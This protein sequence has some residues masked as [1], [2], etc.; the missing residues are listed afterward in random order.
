MYNRIHSFKNN[1]ILIPNLKLTQEMLKSTPKFVSLDI[2]HKQMQAQLYT[3]VGNT[4]M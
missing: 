3:Y 4:L 1:L 2:L